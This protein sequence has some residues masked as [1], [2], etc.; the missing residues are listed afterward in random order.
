MGNRLEPVC[1]QTSEVDT[2]IFYSH[3]KVKLK[4]LESYDE[5]STMRKRPVRK[6][7]KKRQPIWWAPVVYSR[8][9]H[10]VLTALDRFP[11]SEP[12]LKI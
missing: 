9:R 2:T 6:E 3:K 5:G 4:N 1:I 12:I 10:V 11:A 7:V 8:L